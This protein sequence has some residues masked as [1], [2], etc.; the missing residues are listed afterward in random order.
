M[1]KKTTVGGKPSL[2]MLCDS[3]MLG[4]AGGSAGAAVLLPASV[5]NGSEPPSEKPVY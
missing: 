4:W 5:E 2:G 3:V 1:V